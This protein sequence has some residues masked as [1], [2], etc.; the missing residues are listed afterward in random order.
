MSWPGSAR[1]KPPKGTR[2]DLWVGYAPNG[3]GQQKPN[4]YLDMAKVVWANRRRLPYAFRILRKGVCDGC[5]LGVAGFHDWTLSG[6]HLCTTRLNLLEMNTME[7]LDPAVLADV[8]PLRTLDGAE[9][10]GLGRLPYPMVR[11]AGAPGF[12]RV[13]W[14]EALDLIA[15]RIRSAATPDAFALYLTARGITNEVYYAAQKATRAIGTNNVDNAARVCH[16]PSTTALKR[17]IGVAATTCSYTDVIESDLIVLFGSNVAN[18]QPVFMKYLYYARKRG[19]KIVVVNPVREPGLERYWVPSNAESAMFGTKMA[20]EF[21]AVHTGGDIAFVNGVLKAMVAAGSIDEA[22][23]GDHTVGFDAVRAEVEAADWAELEGASGTTRAEMERFAAIY[24]A[25]PT[26]VLVWSMGITQHRNGTDAVTAIANLGLAR[27]HVGRKGSG[28]M[29]IRGHSGV[30]GGAEMGAYATVFPGGITIGVDSA[31]ALAARY[32]FSIGDR[33]GLTAEEM[34]LA[35]G[36]GEIDVLYSSGGNFLDVLP[37]PDAVERALSHV[38]VRVHQDIVVTSQMLVDPGDVV[39]LLPACTRYE[40]RG[41]GTETTT[42]RRVAFSPEVRGPRVGEARA[43]W[44]IFGDLAARVRPELADAVRFT[45][46]DAIRAEISEVVPAYSGIEHLER[47]GD[48]VQWGGPQLGVGGAFSTPDGKAHFTVVRPSVDARPTGRGAFVLSTRRGKQFNS[49][50]YA[51]KDPLTGAVRDAVLL[52]ERDAD[53]L[54]VADG[55]RVTLR[56]EHGEMPARVHVAPIRPGNVQVFFPEGNVLLPV[57]IRD[58]ASG[59][60]DYTTRIDI[61]PV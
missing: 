25:A 50:V 31:A 48:S 16:A 3:I 27:G 8:A 1:V 56:S 13:G 39:V 33:P 15:G 26:A 53:T 38:P 6:V 17:A 30:Q 7:A 11:R 57:G 61:V 21:F 10:R 55:A 36:R 45:D 34:V 41:G 51:A 59:V 49:M 58:A 18:G 35:G 44:E 60:P 20:D 19:A 32:G 5:A 52:S 37:D 54:G 29:P 4:H 40:Q 47:L 24:G 14:D 43:E 28:L 9:L 22:F 46:A 42:E 2:R 23:V 12:I